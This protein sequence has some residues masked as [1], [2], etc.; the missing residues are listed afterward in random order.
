MR[1]FGLEEEKGERRKEAGAKGVRGSR[2]S[3]TELDLQ[4]TILPYLIESS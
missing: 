4:N 2:G 3:F 1:K